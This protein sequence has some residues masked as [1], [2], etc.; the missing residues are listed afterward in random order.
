MTFVSVVKCDKEIRWK[1]HS[2]QRCHHFSTVNLHLGFVE[3]RRSA[4][5]VNHIVST[6][7]LAFSRST[8]EVMVD[9]RVVQRVRCNGDIIYMSHNLR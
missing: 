3:V 1:D 7:A 8:K 9:G 4:R 6:M 5:M 2:R